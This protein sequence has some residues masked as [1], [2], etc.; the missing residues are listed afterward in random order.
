[1]TRVAEWAND[2]DSRFQRPAIDEFL[3]SADLP[4]IANAMAHD[5]TLVTRERSEPESKKRIKIPDVCLKFRVAWT[6]PFNAYRALGLRL[7]A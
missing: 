7:V 5:A 3:D 6:D 1:M 2:Q 4:L